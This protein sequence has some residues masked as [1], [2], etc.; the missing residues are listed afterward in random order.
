VREDQIHS[1]A[2]DIILRSE[3]V[4]GDGRVLDMPSGPTFAPGRVP[5]YLKVEGPIDYS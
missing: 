2:V 4:L 5:G 3:V 1:S